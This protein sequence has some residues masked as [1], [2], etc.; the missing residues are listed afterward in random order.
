M[1]QISYILKNVDQMLNLGHLEIAKLNINK[2][3]WIRPEKPKLE[4]RR[5]GGKQRDTTL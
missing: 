5:F 3:V 4:K 1:Y 2:I